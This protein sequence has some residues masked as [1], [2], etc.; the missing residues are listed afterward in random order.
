[1]RPSKASRVTNY[2]CL[3]LVP[4]KVWKINETNPEDL[5]NSL[6]FD[7]DACSNSEELKWWEYQPIKELDLS[8]NAITSI[9][10]EIAELESLESFMVRKK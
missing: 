10:V 8:C 2:Y 7:I 6:T 5:K 1:M 3:I 9:P 4:D